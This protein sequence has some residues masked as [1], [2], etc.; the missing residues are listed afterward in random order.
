VGRLATNSNP[1]GQ[2]YTRSTTEYQ[3]FPEEYFS[4]ADVKIYFGDVWMDDITGLQFKLFEKVS[5][6]HGYA[7]KTWDY[8]MRGKRFVQGYFKI[9]FR[10]AG[11]LYTL[12]DHL[13][14]I[15]TDY[16]AAPAV[17]YLL[18]GQD[19]PKWHGD[20]QDRLESV[21]ARWGKTADLPETTPRTE[22]RIIPPWSE[23]FLKKGM[24]GASIMTLQQNLAYESYYTGAISGVFD[25]AVEAAVKKK[26]IARGEFPDGIVGQTIKR[27]YSKTEIISLPG[28][29]LAKDPNGWA[30]S[31]MVQYEKDVWGRSFVEGGEEYRKH[32]SFFYRSRSTDANG[33]H[34]Q[35]LLQTGIDMYI[36]YGPLTEF[37]KSQSGKDAISEEVAFN[38]TIKAIRNIQIVDVEQ[39]LD[40]NTGAVIEE[41]YS[42]IARDLD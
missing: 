7:S 39:V 25:A 41:L 13:G 36:N 26:Q 29:A 1:V 23:S 34:T 15:T 28:S 6:V 19:V 10:E 22:T 20:V 8:V 30:E 9:A 42:F 3:L 35:A 27:D 24:T 18:S 5:P 2:I 4:A 40:P 33:S 12:L 21:L 38:T 16:P 31:R 37:L 17:S 11:Y 14:Q 32:E